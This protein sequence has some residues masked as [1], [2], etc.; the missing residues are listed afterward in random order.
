MFASDNQ[1]PVCPEVIAAIA[2][3][4][5][6]FANPY[7]RD[8]VTERLERRISDYFETQAAVIP[9]ATG[10]AANALSLSLITP[11]YGAVYCHEK[12]HVQTT[13]CGATEFWT[14]GGKLLLLP[15]AAHRI[16]P[17]AF[18]GALDVHVTGSMHNVQP[19]GISITQATEA[20]TVYPVASVAE[21]ASIAHARNLLVHMDGAR[22]LNAQVALGC[23][24]ADMTWRAGVDIL[25]FGA[26]KNGGMCADVIIVFKKDLATHSGCARV[27]AGQMFSKMRY[28]SA[29]LDALLRDGVAERNAAHAN[30]MARRL[31]DGLLGIKGVV[32]RYPVEINLVFAEL[33]DEAISSLEAAGY[34]LSPR[35]DEHGRYFRLACSWHT[36]DDNVD[37]FVDAAL[38]G[39]RGIAA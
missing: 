11:R 14:Q 6:G 16:D 19:A 24:A 21:L 12:A 15:G 25:S 31:T 1:A 22:I 5:T 38:N 2:E 26:T 32:L 35:A 7:G 36:S 18:A 20:G 23:S 13:E 30:H 29:Q 4:N 37:A 3:A 8:G 10:T 28:V 39:G 17:R 27:R 9:V 33:P 34:S